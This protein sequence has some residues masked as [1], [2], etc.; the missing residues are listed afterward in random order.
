MLYVAFLT[1]CL[2]YWQNSIQFG[3]TLSRYSSPSTPSE[4]TCLQT[5]C[6]Y[7][8]FSLVNLSCGMSTLQNKVKSLVLNPDILKNQVTTTTPI[9]MKIPWFLW[10]HWSVKYY[11]FII[12]RGNNFNEFCFK[13]VKFQCLIY[14]LTFSSTNTIYCHITYFVE[15]L[16]MWHCSTMKSI[17]IGA[18]PKIWSNHCMQI[19]LF[20]RTYLSSRMSNFCTTSGNG[21][22][23]RRVFSTSSQVSVEFSTSR[24][25]NNSN[26]FPPNVLSQAC[27][28]LPE[29]AAFTDSTE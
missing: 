13:N 16:M 29:Q 18:Q 2:M 6:Q 1:Y 19:K 11:Y 22:S 8:E 5:A 26:T 9:D 12:I 20:Y 14:S 17:K 24:L 23:F 28:S 10:L 27:S 15:H 3:R 25:P 7:M 21:A 4:W